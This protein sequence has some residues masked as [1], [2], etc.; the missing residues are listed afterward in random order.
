MEKLTSVELH[1]ALESRREIRIR[2]NKLDHECLFWASLVTVVACPLSRYGGG[3]SQMRWA[4]K[5][6]SRQALF[7]ITWIDQGVKMH[8]HL[9]LQ[10]IHTTLSAALLPSP[11][12]PP[13]VRIQGPDLYSTLLCALLPIVSLFVIAR[14]TIAYSRTATLYTPNSI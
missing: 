13:S 11:G 10:S 3:C 6:S 14:M 1:L 9:E 7:P 5:S 12:Q 4:Q 8:Y 2:S